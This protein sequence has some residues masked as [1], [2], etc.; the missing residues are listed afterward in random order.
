M[1]SRSLSRAPAGTSTAA[2]RI[3]MQ[4][5]SS[6]ARALP[7]VGKGFRGCGRRA[8]GV[9]AEPAKT[10]EAGYKSL[11]NNGLGDLSC[12][13]GVLLSGCSLR[14]RGFARGGVIEVREEPVLAQTRHLDQTPTN[15]TV[16]LGPVGPV[17]D[18]A[19]HG[20]SAVAEGGHGLLAGPGPAKRQESAAWSGRFG[21]KVFGGDF[22]HGFPCSVV[23][24]ETV[25]N[26]GRRVK[27]KSVRSRIVFG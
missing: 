19:H 3:D 6:M 21:H 1:L 2:M 14:A 11:D 20:A 17:D 24:D 16:Q 15:A 22:V 8:W 7:R 26:R 23:L 5:D 18:P 4:S 25:L 9:Y 27:G 13:R 12:M 10:P